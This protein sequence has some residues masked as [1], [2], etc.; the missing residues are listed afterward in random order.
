MDVGA[1]GG[2]GLKYCRSVQRVLFAFGFLSCCDVTISP[3]SETEIVESDGVDEGLGLDIVR[4]RP[5]PFF[6]KM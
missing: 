6:V 5:I 2:D 3:N 1:G 4:S